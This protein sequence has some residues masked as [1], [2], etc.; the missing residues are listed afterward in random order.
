[1][2]VEDLQIRAVGIERAD[3]LGIAMSQARRVK[4]LAVVINAAGAIDDLILAVVVDV[5]DGEAV[6]ALASVGDIELAV[7]AMPGTSL[8]KTHR[9]TSLSTSNR[10][11]P[12]RC[13]VDAPGHHDAGM[14]AVEVG[15][16]GPEA[17]VVIAH[18]RT[19]DGG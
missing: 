14:H 19:P 3:V 18:A 11:R 15:D 9:W 10:M 5:G 2:D 16:A 7:L 13:G 17:A 4:P 6:V 12:A 1:M 8:S